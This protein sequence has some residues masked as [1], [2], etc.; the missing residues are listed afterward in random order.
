MELGAV[1]AVFVVDVEA[2]LEVPAVVLVA[3]EDVEA[4]VEDGEVDAG[5]CGPW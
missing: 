4:D 1:D 3:V 2:V 5:A